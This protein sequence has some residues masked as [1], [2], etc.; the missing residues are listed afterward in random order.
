[1]NSSTRFPINLVRGAVLVASVLLYTF[2]ILRWAPGRMKRIPT[3]HCQAIGSKPIRLG[4]PSDRWAYLNLR[5]FCPLCKKRAV[6][7]HTTSA[8]KPFDCVANMFS[9]DV[10]W[11][12]SPCGHELL[13]RLPCR[14]CGEGQ[15]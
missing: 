8:F 3:L 7:L 15:W 5:E 14:T 9:V 10:G 4:A 11:T 1:M 12:Y 13:L 6:S 2:A